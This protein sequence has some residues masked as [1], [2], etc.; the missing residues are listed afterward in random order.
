M[1]P[2]FFEDSFRVSA[3]NARYCGRQYEARKDNTEMKKV[4]K[5]EREERRQQQKRGKKSAS[6]NRWLLPPKSLPFRPEKC[7]HNDKE[8]WEI[9]ECSCCRIPYHLDHTGLPGDKWEF[10]T[11]M[12]QFVRLIALANRKESFELALNQAGIVFWH[13]DSHEGNE[14]WEISSAE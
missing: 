3:W 14:S 13:S 1:W 8:N 4:E 9:C 6:D 11:F 2:W 7:A 5:G 10:S 12:A